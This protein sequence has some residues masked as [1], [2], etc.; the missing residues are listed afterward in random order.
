MKI[1]AKEL[2]LIKI[3]NR[4]G[5]KNAKARA[6]QLGKGTESLNTP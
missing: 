1:E 6:G 4:H 3:I 2:T 5:A